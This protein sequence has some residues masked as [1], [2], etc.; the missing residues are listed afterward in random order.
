M[1][2]KWYFACHACS[3]WKITRRTGTCCVVYYKWWQTIS[4]Y[5][6]NRC[7]SHTVLPENNKHCCLDEHLLTKLSLALHNISQHIP[8]CYSLRVSMMP[9]LRIFFCTEIRKTKNDMQFLNS[10][11]WWFPLWHVMCIQNIQNP[12]FFCLFLCFQGTRTHWLI[13]SRHISLYFR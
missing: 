6:Q 9:I 10:S 1:K 3:R 11:Y 7:S 12:S 5:E 2:E 13:W 4:R 8:I